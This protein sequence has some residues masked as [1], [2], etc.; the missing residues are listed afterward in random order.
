VTKDR[1]SARFRGVMLLLAQPLSIPLQN[2]F[3]ILLTAP[4]SA[5][6]GR[7]SPM[8]EMRTRSPDTMLGL[9]AVAPLV[10]ILAPTLT[11]YLW[12]KPISIFG[13]FVVTTFISDSL[14]LTLPS[15][16]SSRPP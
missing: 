15:D 4:P 5:R 13:L 3:A 16:P 8:G 7:F 9:F 6:L 10:G 12:F 2:G 11:T 1:Q 14:L